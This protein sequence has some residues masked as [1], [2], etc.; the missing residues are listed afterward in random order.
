MNDILKEIMTGPEG[1]RL[2]LSYLRECMR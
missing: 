2:A 1:V